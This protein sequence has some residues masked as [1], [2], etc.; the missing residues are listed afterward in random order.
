MKY[1]VHRDGAD[2]TC[3]VTLFAHETIRRRTHKRPITPSRS[4]KVHNHSP[5]GFNFGYGGSGPA[6]LA[7]AIM[8]DFTNDR[9]L[10]LR[11][12]QDFKRDFIAPMKDPGGEIEDTTIFEWIKRKNK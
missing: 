11:L 12:Y 8:M 6:Q 7:L 5:D 4:Q 9:E 3:P 1:V 2:Y 10:A